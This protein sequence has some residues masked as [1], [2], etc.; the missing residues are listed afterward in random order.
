VSSYQEELQRAAAEA[1][2][3]GYGNSENLR[4]LLILTTSK[5]TLATVEGYFRQHHGDEDLLRAL[6]AIAG[7]GEDAG[8][9][10]WAAANTIADFPASMLKKHKEELLELSKHEWLYLK[11]PALDAL[12]KV[13]ADDT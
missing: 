1:I 11:Q 2:E 3:K 10:P 13:T 6:F 7:E 5:T 4:R 8:D 12:A 9:A